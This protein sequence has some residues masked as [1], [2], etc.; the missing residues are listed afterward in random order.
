VTTLFD[1]LGESENDMSAAL[2]YALAHAP[3]FLRRVVADL[4]PDWSGSLKDA[5]VALQT[6]RPDEGITDLELRL[7]EDL[8]AIFEA[9]RGVEFPSVTQLIQYA[10]VA[11]RNPAATRLLVTLT[12][13]SPAAAAADDYPTALHGVPVCHWSWRQVRDLGRAARSAERTLAAKRLLDQ[14]T[15]YLGAILGMETRFSNMVRVVSLGAGRPPGWALGWR[16]V[17]EQYGRYFY[18][19]GKGL[20]DP[21]NY[22]AF[23]YDGRLQSIHHVE[24][25]EVFT[26]PRTLFPEAADEVWQPCYCLTLGPKIV[27]PHVVKN[28]PRIQRG[29]HC[30]C[31]L[32]T[33]LTAA[34]ISDALTETQRRKNAK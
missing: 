13:R 2:G 29:A 30:D 18:P 26:R 19:V 25:V 5:V 6:A 27:P 7:G 33:L 21:P 11:A 17:V 12:N 32:D 9:K 20:P 4:V 23:R 15:S 1:L 10:P 22:I 8:F 14:F 28:G 16:D 34:T 24:A 3:A 31:M